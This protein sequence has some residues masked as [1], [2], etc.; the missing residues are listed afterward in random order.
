M[1]FNSLIFLVVFLPVALA[2]HYAARRVFLAEI[3]LILVSLVF[4]GYWDLR[5]V[6][7][8]LVSIG[9]NW[10]LAVLALNSSRRSVVVAFGI[11]I[12]LHSFG[13]FQICRFLH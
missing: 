8:L 3:Q 1:L 11:A 10:A 5:L 9:V 12:N 7:L 6:P 4:Y 13:T 2:S